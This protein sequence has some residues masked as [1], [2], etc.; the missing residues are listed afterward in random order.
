MSRTYLLR[1]VLLSAAI[2]SVAVLAH[3]VAGAGSEGLEVAE[4]TPV[5][6][7]VSTLSPTRM[8]LYDELPGRVAA[9]RRVEIRPQVGGLIIKRLV[10]EG[11]SVEQGQVLFQID[12]ATLKA[13]LETA[14]AGLKRARA[15]EAHAKR[16]LERA[17]ALLAKNVTSREQ[18]DNA[19]NE[20]ALAEAN[21]AE[22]QAIVDRRR[23][24]LE[25]ATLRSPIRGY[26]GS[27]LVDVGGLA[28]PSS[29]RALAVVQ[30]VERVYVDLRL[31]AARLDALQMAAADDLGPVEILTAGGS[32]HS[33][34]GKLKFSDV[35]VDPG[36]GSA[37]VRI[38]VENPD[39]TL[40][41]GMYV[42]A[43]MPRR[44][45]AD[46]LVVPGDAVLRTGA[47]NAQVVV[48]SPAGQASRRD[49]RLGDA[50]G[51]GV[52]ATSGLKAGEVIAIRGQDRLQDGMTVRSVLADENTAPA[53]GR[54]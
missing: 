46:A 27:G 13:D 10:D 42:R 2:A 36:T 14:E 19:R 39:L 9:Y 35:S 7:E 28:S 8:T 1:L 6:V 22:A 5:E 47:G 53:T 30:D 51:E 31:P 24:D 44:I 38:E 45:L 41:P 49:V 26:V 25:F 12:T 37:S 18:N 4:E 43:R 17:D 34:P 16:G 29:E 20:L 48:I 50:V 23:L 40:L 52:V 11:A 33:Q 32:P 15:A 21:L 3:W 54:L